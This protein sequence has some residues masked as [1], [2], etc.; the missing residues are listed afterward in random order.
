M[1]PD[2]IAGG[3]IGLEQEPLPDD[4]TGA[5]AADKADD[6][7]AQ[8]TATEDQSFTRAQVEEMIKEVTDKMVTTDEME[9]NVGKVRSQ[10]DGARNVERAEW[11]DRDAAYQQTIHNLNVRDLDESDRA[12]YE[13][14]VYYQRAQ[15]LQDRLNSQTTEL[16]ATKQVGPY[17]KHLVDGFGISLAEVDLDNIDTLSQSAFDAATTAHQKLKADLETA[18]AKITSLE[19]DDVSESSSPAKVVNSPDVVTEVGQTVS[20][21]TTLYDL[22][23]SVSQRL[24]YDHVITEEMLFEMGERPEET[25]VDMNVVVQAMTEAAEAEGSEE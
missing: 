20:S 1:A 9:I 10:L 24:G 8:T 19:A 25:G 6:L 11:A 3:P 18:N 15:E 21:P 7:K 5:G 12:Q 13:R 14:D 16:E 17:L 2:A 23:K 4:R 22:R